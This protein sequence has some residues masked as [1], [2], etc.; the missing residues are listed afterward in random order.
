MTAKMRGYLPGQRQSQQ[1]GFQRGLQML[2]LAAAARGRS[3]PLLWRQPDCSPVWWLM[4]SPGDGRSRLL[5]TEKPLREWPQAR[6]PRR[7]AG[8]CVVRTL[9]VRFRSAMP[10]VMGSALLAQ[11]SGLGLGWRR[12]VAPPMGQR[13]LGL[14]RGRA[15]A[16][17]RCLLSNSSY[18][19]QVR[20]H[21]AD[22]ARTASM[23]APPQILRQA[24]RAGPA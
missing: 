23:T 6:E 2:S 8:R 15:G 3:L 17:L 14:A 12:L 13:P 20:C 21:V 19:C 16:R 7:S 9:V 10:T 22:V 24:S 4:L 11:R 1:R 5:S 18:E